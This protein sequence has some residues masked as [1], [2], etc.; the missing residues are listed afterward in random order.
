MCTFLQVYIQA[1]PQD[2]V[3]P[4][5]G[6]NRYLRQVANLRY[7]S[8]HTLSTIFAKHH[9]SLTFKI[10]SNSVL[11]DRFRLYDHC[12][13]WVRIL[14]QICEDLKY[15]KLANSEP[16]AQLANSLTTTQL[17]LLVNTFVY[18]IL[19][20]VLLC[21]TLIQLCRG[22]GFTKCVYRT[23]IPQGVRWQQKIIT[24]ILYKDLG[25][26]TTHTAGTVNCHACFIS[27]HGLW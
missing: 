1:F 19:T 10:C 13:T 17:L 23:P 3:L 26:K 11:V 15:L 22:S 2:A 27:L 14:F 5:A 18:Y 4:S 7:Q 9:F 24:A 21:F 8:L 16:L 25:S 20:N 12:R 6:D